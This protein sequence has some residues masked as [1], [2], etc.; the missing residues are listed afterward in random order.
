MTAPAAGISPGGAAATN[1]PATASA[2]FP[3]DAQPALRRRRGEQGVGRTFDVQLQNGTNV[4]LEY[5][6]NGYLFVDA[7]S[8]YANSGPWRA[9]DGRICSRMRGAEASCN[10]VPRARPAAVP[11]AR[12]RG[13]DRA[14][15]E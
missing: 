15:S 11:E 14:Q 6:S 8:G 13:G 4:R 2:D 10:E 5:K 1:G 12:Q 3:A 9:E 7:A